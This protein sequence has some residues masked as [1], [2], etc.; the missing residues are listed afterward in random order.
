MFFKKEMISFNILD[1]LEIKQKNVTMFNSGRNFSALSFRYRSDTV[2]K[3]Q[4]EEYHM[5]NNFV[6]YVPARLDYQR[7]ANVDELIVI[8][9]DAINY[10][11]RDIECFVS[12][13]PNTLLNLFKEILEVWNKKELGYKHKCSAI[14]YKIF[15]ECYVQN[16]VPKSEISKIQN[17]IDYIL[18][19]YKKSDLSIKEVADKSFMSEVYFRKLFKKEYGISLMQKLNK[20]R[21][22]RAKVLLSSGMF[23]L[24]EVSAACGFQNEYY[25]SRV[26][27][28]HTGISPGKY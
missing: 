14:L 16:F 24:A 18:A 27:K 23:T 17:S 1:V 28:Q 3:T 4:T 12:Q 7:I 15:A 19:N 13:D 8:H 2:L 21:V 20:I 9:F 5:R 25:F 11:S 6:S 10:T 26:F 22:Q